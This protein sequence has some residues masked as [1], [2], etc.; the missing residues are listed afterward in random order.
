MSFNNFICDFLPYLRT[1]AV[2]DWATY[3]FA[4]A[5]GVFGEFMHFLLGLH[6][7]R[8]VHFD[9][10]QGSEGRNFDKCRLEMRSPMQFFL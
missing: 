7:A 1:L 10:A 4:L 9:A 3:F 8:T 6:P 5:Y 2:S